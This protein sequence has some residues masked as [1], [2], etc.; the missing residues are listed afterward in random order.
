MQKPSNLEEYTGTEAMDSE[1]TASAQVGHPHDRA[2]YNPLQTRQLVTLP[3][4]S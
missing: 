2:A 3:N 4:H 1:W